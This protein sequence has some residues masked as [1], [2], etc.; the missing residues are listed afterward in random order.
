MGDSISLE[1][2]FESLLECSGLKFAKMSNQARLST[3]K[4]N[5]INII[6]KLHDDLI[7]LSQNSPFRSLKSNSV[8]RRK[9]RML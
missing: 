2:N 3:Q 4:A 9:Y 1:E 8:N 6:K 5:W 7:V